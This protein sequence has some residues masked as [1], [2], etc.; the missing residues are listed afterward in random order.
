MRLMQNKTKNLIN[1]TRRQQRAKH[2][3]PFLFQPVFI[4]DSGGFF[5]T[6]SEV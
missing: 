6:F 5:T 3:V 4:F 1:F 2:F